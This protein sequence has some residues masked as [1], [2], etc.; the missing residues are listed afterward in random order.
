MRLVDA[1][2]LH[3]E[4]PD[5]V[6]ED[7]HGEEPRRLQLEAA[8]DEQEDADPEQAPERLVQERRVE[9]R[10]ERVVDRAVLRG[11]LERPRQVARLPEQLLVEV[12]APAADRL[13]EQE[14]GRDRV[15]EG[16]DALAGA[17]HDPGAHEHAGADPAPDAEAALPDGEGLPPFV[18][19]RAPARDHVVEAGADDAGEDAPHGDAE[20]EVAARVVPERPAARPAPA[21]H[22]GG[23]DD[24]E[25]EHEPV[26]VHLERAQVDLTARRARNRAEKSSEH[27]HGESLPARR[28][29]FPVKGWYADLV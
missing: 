16:V 19:D 25:Q 28:A 10:G 26:G 23:G 2:E 17:V 22:P 1:Q 6:P 13:R 7:V 5:A 9:G 27:R 18:V 21:R 3:A 4:A 12:V 24:P 11:D 29:R 15:H 8:L 20:D 14:P